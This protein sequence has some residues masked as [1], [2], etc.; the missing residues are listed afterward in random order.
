MNGNCIDGK[1]VAAQIREEL[2]TQV[3]ALKDQYKRVRAGLCFA[4][5]I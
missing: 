1:A 3:A 2:T 5:H 4:V